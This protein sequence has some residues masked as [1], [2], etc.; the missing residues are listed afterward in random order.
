MISFSKESLLH[1]L[2]CG[3]ETNLVFRYKGDPPFHSPKYHVFI[4]VTKIANDGSLV[5][6]NGTSKIEK[7]KTATRLMG[8]DA[9]ETLVYIPSKK[10]SFF[11]KE[12]IIDCN[13]VNVL[14]PEEIKIDDFEYIQ[15]GHLSEDDFEK[16]KQAIIASPLVAPYI[17]NNLKN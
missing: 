3:K 9:D 10:Y 11:S 17:K 8:I 1:M 16:I 5:L 7:R 4:I 13:S 6:V 14:K 15:N 12:T 2:L